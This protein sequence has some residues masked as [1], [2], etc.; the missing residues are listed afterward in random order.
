M[1]LA[2]PTG[3]QPPGTI[4]DRNK[5][6]ARKVP[7]TLH[8]LLE[9]FGEVTFTP[10]ETMPVNVNG[11]RVILEAD[12]PFTGPACFKGVYDESRKARRSPSRIATSIGLV[13]V[14]PWA[15]ALTPEPTRE[16]I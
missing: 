13:E 2:P 14:Y 12:K 4:I 7:W 16:R 15:G 3:K 10:E 9:V 5:L 8:S 1:G 6:T 11:V